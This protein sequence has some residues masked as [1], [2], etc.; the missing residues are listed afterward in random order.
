MSEYIYKGML[1]KPPVR[2][3]EDGRDKADAAIRKMFRG[4]PQT[5]DPLYKTVE[6]PTVVNRKSVQTIK[7]ALRWPHGIGRTA[8][9]E[10]NLNARR[11]AAKPE[12]NYTIDG[13]R[14][15]H[16]ELR[17]SSQPRGYATEFRP[18]D[19]EDYVNFHKGLTTAPRSANATWDNTH[20]NT[21]ASNDWHDQITPA[22]KPT[23]VTF[24]Q[25]GVPGRSS[26][27]DAVDAIKEALT[28]PQR[29]GASPN[30]DD[31]FT[32]EV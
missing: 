1:I 11:K 20:A 6:R 29:M 28:K 2:K 25:F 12:Y 5:P 18:L 8:H 23:R 15:V 17:K 19:P 26:R 13:G 31:S 32:R 21:G 24:P 22:T 30:V 7:K 14:V 3:I 9:L 16:K 10:V 27:D 4:G